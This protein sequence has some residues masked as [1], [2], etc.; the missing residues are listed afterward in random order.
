MLKT[1]PWATGMSS[2]SWHSCWAVVHFAKLMSLKGIKSIIPIL[3][4]PLISLMYNYNWYFTEIHMYKNTTMLDAHNLLKQE[5]VF[6]SWC[7]D[8]CL[9]L[10]I[11]ILMNNVHNAITEPHHKPLGG[12]GGVYG[13]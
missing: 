4:S 9:Q 13:Y 1:N 10:H 12:G 11:Y 7:P 2:F 8:S 6:L 3:F 5:Y